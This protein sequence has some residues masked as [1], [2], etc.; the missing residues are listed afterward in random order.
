MQ[1]KNKA[2]MSDAQVEETARLFGIL[3]EPSRLKLLRTLMGGALTVTE[4]IGATGLKQANVSK[5]LGVLLEANFVAKEKEGNFARYSIAD[6]HLYTLCE[7]MCGRIE[8]V[9]RAR[10]A[11]LVPG[12]SVK[13]Q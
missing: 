2:V 11:A 12:S 13:R 4:L 3:S 1:A 8:N 7:L 9:A 6:P 10:H 5:Q